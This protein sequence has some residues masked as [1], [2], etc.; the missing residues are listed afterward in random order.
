MI[1]RFLDEGLIQTFDCNKIKY[2]E[3]LE[4]F[5]DSKGADSEAVED[6]LKELGR[7]DCYLPPV[8]YTVGKDWVVFGTIINITVYLQMR[9]IL[10]YCYDYDRRNMKKWFSSSY[11]ST[12]IHDTEGN[13]IRLRKLIEDGMRMV[14]S[15]K[16]QRNVENLLE[17]MFRGK[18][19]WNIGEIK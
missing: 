8:R 4:R 13:R 1:A 10:C 14:S 3:F 19:R 9:F 11:G 18:T 7:E 5:P 15:A 6:I 2:P 16:H 12:S 17:K